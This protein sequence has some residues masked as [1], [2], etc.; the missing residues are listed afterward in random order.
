M[1]ALAQ[2]RRWSCVAGALATSACEPASTTPLAASPPATATRQAAPATTPT[3][4]D[5]VQP[6]LLEY[7]APCHLGPTPDGCI[8]ATCMPFFYESLTWYSCC[9]APY[10]GYVTEPI[11]GCGERRVIDCSMARIHSFANNG[12]DPLPPDQLEILEAWVA[13]G[14]PHGEGSDALW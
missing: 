11:E 8:G 12:K 10:R 3:F 5:D 6:I 7:C 14:I 2:L 4:V 13:A 9:K 1:V